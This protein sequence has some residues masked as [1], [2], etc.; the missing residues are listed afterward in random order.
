VNAPAPAWRRWAPAALWATVLVVATSVPNPDVP[1]ALRPTDKLVHALLYGVLGWLCVRALR[2]DAR[3]P[4]RRV[5]VLG[6]ILAFAWLDEWHQQFVPGRAQDAADW[7][8]DGIGAA[9]AILTS[10]ARRRREQPT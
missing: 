3:T 1:S 10:S 7:M 6:V 2:P 4:R 5:V 9:V 8:A